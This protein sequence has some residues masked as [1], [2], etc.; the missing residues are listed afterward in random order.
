M[1]VDH[2]PVMLEGQVAALSSGVL[3]SEEV[4]A[5]VDALY[6]SPLYRPD[7]NSFILYP[8]RE[9][10]GFLEKN[11]ISE[12]DV[13][14][15]PLLLA[16]LDA[17]DTTVVERDSLGTC[18][19]AP[20]VASTAGLAGALDQL[21]AQPQWTE[22]VA[23]HRAAVDDTFEKVFQHRRFTGRSGSMYK[24]EGLGS[25]YW[26]MVAKLLLAVQEAFWRSRADGES[27]ETQNALADAYYRIRAGLSSDKTPIQYGA[28][29]TDPYSHSP[30]HMGAQQPGMT[31]QVKEEVLTRWGELGIRIEDGK[32]GF[33]PVL[34]RRRELLAE[35]RDWDYYAVTGQKKTLEVPSGSLAFTYCQVPII[36]HL[37]ES[38]SVKVLRANGGT[39][40]YSSLRLDRETSAAVFERKGEI[41]VIEVTLPKG[42]AITRP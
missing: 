21:S 33:D 29:P 36:Y 8:A 30:A 17:G 25:I 7:Q 31:G 15:N 35:G 27:G 16:L 13:D 40:V 41:E 18:R 38:G 32:I 6:T 12:S 2:L 28:F 23:A 24:Y 34:L 11:A 19:F 1:A 39:S 37:G 9:L 5:I 14:A 20:S 26:H 42:Q 10:P 3:S 4:L 22:L